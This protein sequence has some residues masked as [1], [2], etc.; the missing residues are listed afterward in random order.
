[1]VGVLVEIVYYIGVVEGVIFVEFVGWCIMV[2]F[3]ELVW[4]VMFV[5]SSGVE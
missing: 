2:K 4:I 3:F 1:M 5:N